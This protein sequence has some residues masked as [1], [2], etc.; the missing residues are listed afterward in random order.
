MSQNYFTYSLSNNDSELSPRQFGKALFIT[1]HFGSDEKGFREK[2]TIQFPKSIKTATNKR[3]FVEEYLKLIEE[4]RKSINKNARDR[5]LRGK[6]AKQR[7]ISD[8]VSSGDQILPKKDLI[9]WAMNKYF[10]F[11]SQ[12]GKHSFKIHS[13][14][15]K[16][17]L[18][19]ISATKDFTKMGDRRTEA[20]I[21]LKVYQNFIF[22]NNE[23]PVS[24]FDKKQKEVEKQLIR[25]IVKPIIPSIKRI[26]GIE[27]YIFKLYNIQYDNNNN[28]HLG[29]DNKY[30]LGWSTARSDELNYKGGLEAHIDNSLELFYEEDKKSAKEYLSR[31]FLSKITTI[32][33]LVEK[34]VE[35]L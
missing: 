23:I 32:G 24:P 4:R 1:I 16:N 9:N 12:M 30:S 35:T 15:I 7:A 6:Q 5:R 10:S 29:A 20:S 31:K 11:V 26:K 13:V 21:A 8:D 17:N 22:F 34:L 14:K 18:I 28:I 27:K 33:V 25:N 19:Y 2:N 3:Q